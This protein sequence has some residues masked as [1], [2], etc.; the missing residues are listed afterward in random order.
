VTAAVVVI[1][2]PGTGKSAVLDALSTLLERGGVMHGAIESEELTRGFPA[3]SNAILLEQL[4]LALAVQRRAGRRLFLIAF[5][6]ES[7]S[8]LRAVL[9]ATEAGRTLVVCL[10][11]PADVLAERLHAREPDRWPGKPGLIVHARKLAEIVPA[12]G[13]IDLE[14]ESEG[15]D[16]EDLARA[17]LAEMGERRL[18]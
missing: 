4:E 1:G 9:D 15:R 10:Y 7:D 17:A 2:A 16:A 14:L 3:L 5:T 13:G 8:E 6:P 12:L 11:A 18:L